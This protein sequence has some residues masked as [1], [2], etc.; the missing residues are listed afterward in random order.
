[1]VP[2]ACSLAK[3]FK[4][5]SSNVI[6]CKKIGLNFSWMSVSLTRPHGHLMQVSLIAFQQELDAL[7]FSIVAATSSH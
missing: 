6:F 2:R 3:S 4:K 1:M 7:G 5:I